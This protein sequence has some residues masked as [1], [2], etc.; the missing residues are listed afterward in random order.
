LLLARIGQAD[1]VDMLCRSIYEAALAQAFVCRPTV[2][3]KQANGK[4]VD[5]YG[6]KLTQNFRAQL[7]AAHT[8]NRDETRYEGMGQKSG[9]KQMAARGQK[10]GDPTY[11]AVKAAIGPQ[12]WQKL[13]RSTTCAG[14]SVRGLAH[15]LGD[16]FARWYYA[17]YSLHSDQVHPAA[18]HRFIKLTKVGTNLCW[19][20]AAYEL[21]LALCYATFMI[22]L[23]AGEF[24]KLLDKTYQ[25]YI[26]AHMFDETYPEFK[27]VFVRVCPPTPRGKALS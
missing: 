14:L 21:E 17:I 3:L 20:D 7:F 2:K 25:P 6:R 9:L 4:P 24:A 13:K 26:D 23:A 11:S 22:S 27:K 10:V 18:F 15:S 8:F 19:Q 16:G 12:W 5:L 1:G